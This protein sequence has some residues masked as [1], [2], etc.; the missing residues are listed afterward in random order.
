MEGKKE[1]YK[2]VK[3]ALESRGYRYYGEE[4]IKGI[5]S[6]HMSK[7]DYIAV[8][9]DIVVIGEIKSPKEGPTSASWRQVQNSDGEEF[10]KVRL[11]VARREKEGKI[12]REVGG[13][14][15]IIR[16]QIPD[17]LYK[18]NKTYKVP[19]NLGNERTKGGYTV[20]PEEKRNTRDAFNSCQILIDETIDVGNRSVTFVFEMR[21]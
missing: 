12:S 20:P 5:G 15:I 2:K 17:Y 10:K 3:K 4:D 16:G 19:F 9:G 8:K 6:S 13:H 18:M 11:D 7:P 14:E 21:Q 1:F